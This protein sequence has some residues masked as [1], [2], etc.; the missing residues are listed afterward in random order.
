MLTSVYLCHKCTGL[1]HTIGEPAS[2]N[3]YSCNCISGYVRDWQ[4]TTPIEQV[5]DL[6]IKAQLQWL[7]LYKRQ[8]RSDD[9]Y[10]VVHARNVLERL[11]GTNK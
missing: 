10:H 1:L 3:Y 8:G 7:D 9:S 6:Q 2:T 4:H 11:R 5:R